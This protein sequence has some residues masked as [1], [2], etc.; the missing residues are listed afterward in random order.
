MNTPPREYRIPTYGTPCSLIG[1]PIEGTPPPYGTP[2][3][4]H[5]GLSKRVNSQ[6]HVQE[7][8]KKSAKRRSRCFEDEEYNIE[9]AI[10]EAKKSGLLP[11]SAEQINTGDGQS[12]NNAVFKDKN[13]VY[14]IAL[15]EKIEKEINAYERLPKG[16][17]KLPDTKYNI[18]FPE[19]KDEPINHEYALLKLEL[20]KG[21]SASTLIANRCREKELKCNA[22]ELIGKVKY[23]LESNGVIYNEFD[24]YEHDI[25]ALGNMYLLDDDKTIV[26]I[27]FEFSKM[28]GGKRRN[29]KKSTRKKKSLKTKLKRRSRRTHKRGGNKC[30]RPYIIMNGNFVITPQV[31]S[32]MQT[33]I[34]E[35]GNDIYYN[36]QNLTQYMVQS[37]LFDNY[38]DQ[39]NLDNFKNLVRDYI[40]VDIDFNKRK[41]YDIRNKYKPFIIEMNG[42]PHMR[43]CSKLYNKLKAEIAIIIQDYKLPKTVC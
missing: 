1:T 43:T 26:V 41:C 16:T 37:I 32:E 11:K 29:N 8:P 14:K 2:P 25:E 33:H 20:I 17:L 21:L 18:R 5:F 13:F 39:N 36:N 19:A 10:D 23:F 4:S 7:A 34:H 6:S 38:Y 12:S 28:K 9:A 35:E 27:D 30:D 24:N 42:L 22:A 31:L 15:K 3:C 40:N